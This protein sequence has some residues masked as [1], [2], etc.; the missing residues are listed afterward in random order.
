MK[1]IGVVTGT[2]AEYGLLKPVMQK[3]N[4]DSELKLCLIVTGMHLEA[5][6]GDTYRQIEKDGFTIH[7]R[8]PMG[9]TSDTPYGATRSMAI[10]LDGFAGIFEMEKLDMVVVLGDRYEI[11][12]AATAA[13]I[14]RVPI[15]HIH[16]GELTEGAMDDAIRHAITKMSAIHFASTKEYAERIIQMGEQPE[17]VFCVGA[18]GVENIK[19]TALLER[20]EVCDKYGEIFRENYMM[21][22]YHP[23]TLEGNSA[24][25]QFEN[26]LKVLSGHGE[27][28]YIFTGA[29][30]DPE[31][32][33]INKMIENYVN[34]K[35]NAKAFVSMGQTGYLSALK[36]SSAVVG[37]SSSGIIEAPSFCIPT[38]NIGMRQKGRIRAGSV[39]D[40][41]YL[42][43]EIEE[44]FQKATT[45]AFLA[46]CRICTN[47]YEGE[48]TS[49]RI[50][51]GIKSFLN[52]GNGTS[53][54]FYDIQK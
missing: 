12:I 26:L 15:A 31:G 8:N 47:P 9:L 3:I 44:A 30:S 54:R 29:N 32:N 5:H 40:C 16:G 51:S 41:G 23:V 4:Q 25:W 2:R 33:V 36:Y 28:H 49:D 24:G 34:E 50:I 46:E 14:Y 52:E 48:H 22:T 27:Y 43:E 53:K 38:V 20:K 19:E 11:L 7:C 37:N 6:F 17:R 45:E 1:K 18:L 21:V 35:K 13:M 10:E 39:I 42:A